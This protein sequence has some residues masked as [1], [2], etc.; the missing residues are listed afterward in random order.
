MEAFVIFV[1]VTILFIIDK[2][3]RDMARNRIIVDLQQT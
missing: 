3:E 2:S 1:I